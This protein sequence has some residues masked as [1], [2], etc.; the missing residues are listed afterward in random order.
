MLGH[1]AAK[2][3]GTFHTEGAT[4]SQSKWQVKLANCKY[5]FPKIKGCPVIMLQN[6]GAKN[7]KV[8][9]SFLAI[10]SDAVCMMEESEDCKFIMKPKGDGCQLISLNAAKDGKNGKLGVTRKGD[11]KTPSEVMEEHAGRWFIFD[12]NDVASA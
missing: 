8:S 4:G 11:I 9:E 7:K 10:K 2:F 1:C 5:D 3:Q 6:A 12:I